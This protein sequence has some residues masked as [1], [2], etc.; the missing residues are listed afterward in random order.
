MRYSSCWR[1]TTTWACVLCASS[2]SSRCAK[3]PPHLVVAFMAQGQGM[4]VE[5]D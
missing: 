4:L 1:T 2:M 5:M 3:H